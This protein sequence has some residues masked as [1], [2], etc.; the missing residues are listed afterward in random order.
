MSLSVPSCSLGRPGVWTSHT[1]QTGS[2]TIF[3]TSHMNCVHNCWP[4]PRERLGSSL[5]LKLYCVIL[6]ACSTWFCHDFFRGFSFLPIFSV[7][8]NISVIRVMEK[9]Q[10]VFWRHLIKSSPIGVSRQDHEGR[11]GDSCA[12]FHGW[13]SLAQRNCWWF[14]ASSSQ[15]HLKRNAINVHETPFFLHESPFLS[16]A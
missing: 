10:G 14:C 8:R 9:A 13:F 11:R 16:T 4:L 2:A 12:C 6:R 15:K 3:C 1:G 7:P 5:V